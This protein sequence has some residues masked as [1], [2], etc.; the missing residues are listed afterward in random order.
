MKRLAAIS[1]VAA[2]V[3]LLW[4]VHTGTV[5]GAAYP[6][7]QQPIAAR[8]QTYDDY[9]ARRLWV[10]LEVSQPVCTRGVVYLGDELYY[11]PP[12]VSVF[13]IKEG[14]MHESLLSG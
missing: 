11:V 9:L 7:N 1:L 4:S 10:P 13:T 2:V 14:A 3:L 5:R 12:D 8:W 6:G